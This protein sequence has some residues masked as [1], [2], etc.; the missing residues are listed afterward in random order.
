[1]PPKRVVQKFHFTIL[2]IEVTHGSR[3]LSVIA[4]LLVF[5][6]SGNGFSNLT[7]TQKRNFP[8]VTFAVIYNLDL[9]KS[10]VNM[11]KSPDSRHA[12]S[13]SQPTAL[14]SHKIVGN[15]S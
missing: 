1:M 8:P 12:D 9:D 11:F 3:G 2:R 13:H 7:F 14:H 6:I 5:H 10:R 15:N 4:E